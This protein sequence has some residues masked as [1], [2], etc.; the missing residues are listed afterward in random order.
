MPV[1]SPI[2]LSAFTGLNSAKA[3]HLLAPSEAVEATNVDT[4]AGTLRGFYKPGSP[5]VAHFGTGNDIGSLW[6][7]GQDHWKIVTPQNTIGPNDGTATY[8]VFGGNLEVDIGAALNLVVGLPAAGYPALSG[9]GSTGQ[10]RGYAVTLYNS[11][12]GWESNPSPIGPKGVVGSRISATSGKNVGCVLTMPGAPA[13]PYSSTS[14]TYNVYATLLGQPNDRLYLRATG[15]ALAGTFTDNDTDNSGLDL[16][17]EL[18]WHVQGFGGDTALDHSPPPTSPGV[19]ASAMQSAVGPG[20]AGVM[21]MTSADGQTIYWCSVNRSAYWPFRNSAPCPEPVLALVTGVGETYALT[22]TGIYALS[23]MDDASIKMRRTGSHLGILSGCAATARMTPYGVMFL[24]REGL[25]LFDGYRTRVI[26]Q[27]VIDPQMI[28][29][30]NFKAGAYF[31]RRYF[32][33]NADASDFNAPGTSSPWVPAY[34]CLVFDMANPT[35]PAVSYFNDP[36][37]HS[38]VCQMM[39][40]HVTPFN[41]PTVSGL[42]VTDGDYIYPWQPASGAAFSTR[43]AWKWK[44]P[45]LTAGL[46]T[47][48][49]TWNTMTVTG[50]GTVTV[51]V[52]Y[53]P[54]SAYDN[55]APVH[56]YPL[57]LPATV[58]RMPPQKARACYLRISGT[59]AAEVTAI[60]IT[61]EVDNGL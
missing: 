37:T 61:C 3:P 49:K 46:P 36:L 25:A 21:F 57:T 43:A 34:G 20:G 30:G 52:F 41:A 15:I 29:S 26:S 16:N 17:T 47:R 6:F 38:S 42:Y 12:H 40:A 10:D 1:P 33:L 13:A 60:Q 44:T 22:R 23:G 14:V 9:G 56:S 58:Q 31:D 55:S 4:S 39:N 35:S 28:N 19:V 48:Y 54:T 45:A 7:A 5:I 59:A 51:D 27:D 8:F 11:A 53:D 2:I 18:A 24:S 32:L 50:T